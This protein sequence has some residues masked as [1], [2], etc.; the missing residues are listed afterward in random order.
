MAIY[1]IVH[2]P[3]LWRQFADHSHLSH[4]FR[5]QALS[6]RYVAWKSD[7]DI[8]SVWSSAWIF[9]PDHVFDILCRHSGCRR[10]RRGRRFVR[11]SIY[12][13]EWIVNPAL[14]VPHNFRIAREKWVDTNA[15]S[16][17]SLNSKIALLFCDRNLVK[18]PELSLLFY[19]NKCTVN[20][21]NI[22]MMQVWIHQI[23]LGVLGPRHWMNQNNEKF[24]VSIFN[25]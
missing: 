4:V 1:Q 3:G 5:G 17:K 10:G 11:K 9:I 22:W 20:F 16:T 21:P 15:K 12:V 13:V 25:M 18:L 23:K 2:F 24:F 8:C 14:N 19:T 7:P 6:E